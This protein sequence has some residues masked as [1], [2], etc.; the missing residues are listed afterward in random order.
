[1]RGAFARCLRDEPGDTTPMRSMLAASLVLAMLLT[2]P[3]AALAGGA[4]PQTKSQQKCITSFGGAAAQVAKARAAENRRCFE[5]FGKGKLASLGAP[6][7]RSCL[8]R[9]PKGKLA[10]QIAKLEKVAEKSCSDPTDVPAF[11]LG[12][13]GTRLAAYQSTGQTTASVLDLLSENLFAT[14]LACGDD[15]AGCKCQQAVTAGAAAVQDAIFG[16]F[17]RCAKLALK[18]GAGSAAELGACFSAPGLP[19]SVANDTRQ[20][21]EKQV[22]KLSKAID[23]RCT[24]VGA[25]EPFPG[26]CLGLEG[27]ALAAC[28]GERVECRACLALNAIHGLDE[29]CDLADDGDENGSCP[30]GAVAQETFVIPSEATPAE[31]PGTPGVVVTHP[32]LLAQFGG[33]DFDLNR[34]TY[35]RYHL[36]RPP[37][38]QPDA[39]LILVPGFE[40][41]AGGFKILAEN[42]IP[43]AYAETGKVFEVWG[44]DRRSHQLED[45][46]GLELAEA[47]ADPQ[48]ALDWL[49]G[50]A[51]ALDLSP[52]LSRRAEFYDHGDLPFFANW[53]Y[54]TH[55]QDI[56][57]VVE[58]AQLAARDANVFLGGHS[59]GTGFAARYAATDFD[60]SGAGP[61][62]PG[63][64][65]LRGLVL[66]EGGGGSSAGGPP[67]DATLDL[68]EA[69]FDGGLFAAVSDQAPRCA[70]GLTPCT[71]ETA[72]VDCAALAVA[73]CAPVSAYANFAGLLSPELL[74][75]AESIALQSTVDPDGGQAILQVE[76]NGIP[77]NTAAAKVPEL[78]ALGALLPDA[79]AQGLI[80]RFV[81]D[82]GLV[83]GFA[84]FVA[85]SAGAEG[86]VVDGLATW[87]DLD[88]AAAFPPCPGM[89]CVTPDNGPQPTAADAGIWGVEREEIRMERLVLTLYAG[90]TN[91]T[92][93][94]Y[95]SSGLSVT[96]GLPSLDSSALSLDAPLGRGR[97]DI[98][99]VTQ[100][101]AIDV[102]VIAFGGSNG[103]ASIP[104]D[105]VPF[106][107]SI[108]PCAAPS[109]DGSTQRLVD[110]AVPSE[111]FP[112]F[113][114]V[115]GGFEVYIS[116]GYAHVDPLAA[117]DG[118]DNQVVQP[119]AEFLSRNA[120]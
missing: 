102:P 31:T 65:R 120:P 37:T 58:V 3:A 50:D 44:F 86:P 52:E 20:K 22:L 64:A 42:L 48:L 77:G 101:A 33:G 46:A 83:A 114:D 43:R 14:A 24:G 92:D 27:E 96:Q 98:D 4:G 34:A 32:K 67:S 73:T 71:E 79:T 111:A 41:G 57:A 9:D 19:G 75:S 16:E 88:E 97:R 95:P 74:A 91:F 5:A 85:M 53:T 47:N 81:D 61:A 89:G 7:L 60:L 11:G 78:A 51:L 55:S 10:K 90:E 6:S 66:L 72:A 62:L 87:L 49:F 115:E 23:K 8:A 112:T 63:Y 12:P 117:E 69:K 39:I 21:I 94:Y 56:D 68:I 76:Q 80:G 113:G 82:D 36:R 103:L 15:A 1:M 118:P 59:A 104:A 17:G 13:G 119:L 30:G 26:Q 2:L 99:N 93:W 38:A 40:G 109:C 116:E 18:E 107:S 25:A 54:L 45:L 108:A 105:F 35:T 29:A 28:V 106:A 84:A 70:D 110:P 100:A